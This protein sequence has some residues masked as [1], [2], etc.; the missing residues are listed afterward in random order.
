MSDDYELINDVHDLLPG[1]SDT[2]LGVGTGTDSPRPPLASTSAVSLKH[3][4]DGEDSGLRERSRAPYAAAVHVREDL[5]TNSTF[6]A[7]H[8]GDT[9]GKGKERETTRESS[10]IG[11]DE[12]IPPFSCHIW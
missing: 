11:A 6:D 1:P 9:K 8:D 2:A 10:E 5:R 12:A 4:T 3:D 7:T